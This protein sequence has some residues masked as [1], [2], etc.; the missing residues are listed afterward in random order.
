MDWRTKR[1]WV[2]VDLAALRRNAA[3]VSR[4]SGRPI[5][6]M[7]KAD[8][9][10]LGAVPVARA[11]RGPDTWG[12]GVATVTEVEELRAAGITGPIVVF[13]PLLPWDY[14]ALRAAAGIPTLGSPAAIA[15]WIDSGGGSW[16][17]A[18]DTGMHRAGIEWS[19]VGEVTELLRRHPPAGAFTHFHS[20]DL[21]DGSMAVQ[22][23]RLREALAKL[24]IRPSLVHAE[25]SPGAERQ[26]PSPWDIV[27]PGVFLYGVGGGAGSQLSPEAVATVRARVVELHDVPTG[28]GVS[29]GVT[30]KAT[31]PSKVATLPV[32]YADGYRRLFS[33]CGHVLLNGQRAPVIGRVTMDMTMIDVTEIPCAPGDTATLLGRA[34]DDHLDVNVIG[35]EVGL[36]S[37]E[38][39]VG[40]RLRMPRVYLGL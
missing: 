39:L 6:P 5:L 20:A 29:Y 13:S 23:D 2:E 37:Y 38:L 25:N 35:E 24:P 30:W 33:S 19:R 14:P 32:G 17:L 31:R 4:H 10:G 8:A 15:A 28:E 27:R 11:L 36:L 16:H 21:N 22:Q 26:G 3:Q 12:F 34:G 18:I 1:S 9:Y 40:L 7:V